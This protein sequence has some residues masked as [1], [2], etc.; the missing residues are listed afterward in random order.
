MY[1]WAPTPHHTITRAVYQSQCMKRTM[2][3]WPQAPWN[4]PPLGS[5]SPHLPT[6][7][8]APVRRPLPAGQFSVTASPRLSTEIWN[9]IVKVRG[10]Q[11]CK[12]SAALSRSCVVKLNRMSHRLLALTRQLTVLCLALGCNCESA[13]SWSRSHLYKAAHFPTIVKAVSFCITLH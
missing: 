6:W 9:Q 5:R 11:V 3:P 8:S 10:E 7:A 2:Y 13:G 1:P 12:Y 4:S